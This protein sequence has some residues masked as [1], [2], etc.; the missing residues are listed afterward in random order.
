MVKESSFGL[1]RALIMET[2][3]KTTFMV[4]ESIVGLMAVSTTVNG[5]I[6]RWKAKVPSL[7]VTEEDMKE[8]TR[9]IKSTGM[10]HLSGLMA[11]STSVTG[12]K[13]NNME[14]E[15]TSTQMETSSQATSRMGLNLN[16]A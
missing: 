1:I 14:R 11:G 7:G 9:M 16:S 8:T 10:V 5:S 15:S 2:S 12:A 13:V 3:S 4:K 6:T